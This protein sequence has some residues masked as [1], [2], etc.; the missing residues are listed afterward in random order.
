MS[1]RNK[2]RVPASILFGALVALLAV[3]DSSAVGQV[4]LI[5]G[6][7][8]GV[9]YVLTGLIPEAGTARRRVRS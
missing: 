4:A 8:L 2:I 1:T 9:L 5:G 3:L 7:A 6:I